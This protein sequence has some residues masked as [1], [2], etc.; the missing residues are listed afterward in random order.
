MGVRAKIVSPGVEGGELSHKRYSC[1]RATPMTSCIEVEVQHTLQTHPNDCA[2][3]SR[4]VEVL[5]NARILLQQ[6]A[7]QPVLQR[8]LDG[9]VYS[10]INTPLQA[11]VFTGTQKRTDCAIKA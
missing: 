10:T 3:C 9:H 7:Y 11:S 1:S 4:H 8:Q 6:V 5:N 2:I